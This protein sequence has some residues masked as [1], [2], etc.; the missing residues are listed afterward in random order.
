MGTL[1]LR[2]A[3]LAAVICPFGLVW[4][5]AVDIDYYGQNPFF[6]NYGTASGGGTKPARE[7][8]PADW[9]WTGTEHSEAADAGE[10]PRADTNTRDLLEHFFE[11]G[12][13]NLFLSS[14]YVY[15]T[16]YSYYAYGSD[17][18]A[19]SGDIFGFSIGGTMQVVN[20]V[21]ADTMNPTNSFDPYQYLPTERVISPS[22]AYLQYNYKDMFQTNVGWLFL[23]TPWVTSLNVAALTQQT[24]QGIQTRFKPGEDWLVTG[25]ALNGFKY[26][27]DNHF[28]R[29]TM[30]NS[31]YNSY[32]D[33]PT[34]VNQ[35]SAGTLALGTQY[36]PNK[37]I[38]AG[39]WGYMFLNYVNMLYADARYDFKLG[40]DAS[41]SLSGQTGYQNGNGV[42]HNILDDAGFGMPESYMFGARAIY[43]QGRFELG[44]S[45]NS[46][47][48]PEDSYRQ[49]GWV[50]P[51]TY[52]I[53]TDPLFTTSWMGGLVEKSGGNAIK[54]APSYE[55]IKNSVNISA[56]YAYY[57]NAAVHDASEWDFIIH[58]QVPQVKGLLIQA[59]YAALKQDK[60]FS[61]AQFM[62]SYVY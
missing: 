3:G 36:A 30:Y 10:M 5:G 7:I 13:Y 31:P 9:N 38:Y 28:S 51:Y 16:P 62:I 22:Q 25:L 24:Y 32:S 4:A 2:L 59:I 46:I 52:T 42:G 49:G 39:L 53:A 54:V 60:L 23:D 26:L 37:R 61:N 11:D 27:D 57:D 58:Y 44:L 21:L 55:L 12:T 33:F 19:Q 15:E 40:D 56:N 1:R 17:L 18:F 48:G 50:S 35:E 41:L 47:F 45:Y 8:D 14:S 20:P 34:I 43:S 6:P 29:K